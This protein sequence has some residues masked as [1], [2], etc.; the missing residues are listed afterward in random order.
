MIVNETV[1]LDKLEDGD[2]SSFQY[3]IDNAENDEEV[4]AILNLQNELVFGDLSSEEYLVK[5]KNLIKV[6]TGITV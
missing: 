2:L 4:E 1:L 6:L 3:L 5:R